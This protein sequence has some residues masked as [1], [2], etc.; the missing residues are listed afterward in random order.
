MKE[1][2][3]INNTDKEKNI[4][5][6][7]QKGCKAVQENSKET[8]AFFEEKIDLEI[9]GIWRDVDSRDYIAEYYD[10]LEPIHLNKLVIAPTHKEVLVKARQ[11]VIWLNPGM[12]FGSGHHATTKMAL[13]SLER[14]E[15]FGKSVLDLGSGSG[16]LAIAADLL[17]AKEVLGIDID[18]LT[19]P[20]AQENAEMNFARASFKEAT[21]D[22]LADNSYDIIVA[23]I[24]AEVHEQL[25][26]D[27]LRVLKQG[28]ELVITGIML[29]KLRPLEELVAKHFKTKS[30]T[31]DEWALIET[32]L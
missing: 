3:I 12:A 30:Y 21:I 11:K 23:N 22:S 13:Q 19:I 9:D 20:V 24:Y 17:G 18:A 16:I 29:S 2:V 5:Y 25:L 7:W 28:G 1:F 8:I 6:L 4:D 14:K 15:L 10:G 26:S 32:K 31:S 27:Y